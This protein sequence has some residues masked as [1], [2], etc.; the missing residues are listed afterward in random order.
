MEAKQPTSVTKKQFWMTCG[1]TTSKTK[2]HHY[3]E[4]D[5]IETHWHSPDG[6]KVWYAG[7]PALDFNNLFMYA[8]PVAVD[9]LKK[10]YDNCRVD[11]AW[12]LLVSWWLRDLINTDFQ[13]STLSLFWVLWEVIHGS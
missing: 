10:N 3:G 11:F 5:R 8:V 2:V 6:E 9:C 12:N 1:F 13:D 7:I 4:K